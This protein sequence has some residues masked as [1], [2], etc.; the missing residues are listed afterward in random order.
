MGPM[1]A[2]APEPDWWPQPDENSRA[3]TL[4]DRILVRWRSPVCAYLEQAALAQDLYVFYIAPEIQPSCPAC[5]IKAR[6]LAIA[7]R[8][9][10]AP[11]ERNAAVREVI[12]R[13]NFQGRVK[14]IALFAVVQ[15]KSP[16]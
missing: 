15:K 5:K 8:E 10:T 6:D 12:G 13:Y 4:P 9:I 11:P 7:Q 3:L 16:Y 2:P 14:R 1:G